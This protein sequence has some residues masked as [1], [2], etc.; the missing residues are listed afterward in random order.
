MKS[1]LLRYLDRAGLAIVVLFLAGGLLWMAGKIVSH[2][3]QLQQAK[4]RAARELQ[5]L[6]LAQ[7]NLLA[8]QAALSQVRSE[9]TGLNDRI[10]AHVEMGA[11]IKELTTRMKERQIT[12]VTLQP[13][14]TI[15]EELYTK[16]PM[17]LVFHG[18]FLQIYSFFYDLQTMDKL[19]VPEKITITGSD[20]SR[21]NCQ[22]EL[23]LF[24]LERKTAK[25]AGV[26][27]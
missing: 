16:V 1:S 27:D 25:A 13:Q 10:P 15:P 4:D 19:L 5:D 6:R 9:I 26:K 23:M 17:R 8:I 12:L 22:V 24:A 18:S 7:S 20:S 2:E 11:L 21:G 3:R 14:T